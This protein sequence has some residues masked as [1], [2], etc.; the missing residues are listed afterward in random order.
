[1]A[2]AISTIIG[3]SA[4]AAKSKHARSKMR[5]HFGSAL[6]SPP[7]GD[8]ISGTDVPLGSFRCKSN[9]FGDS[10]P[11]TKTA[12]VFNLCRDTWLRS[13]RFVAARKLSRQCVGR[14]RATVR[15]I[16]VPRTGGQGAKDPRIPKRIQPLFCRIVPRFRLQFQQLRQVSDRR[17]EA[18]AAFR[19]AAHPLRWA[20]ESDDS[21]G[22]NSLIDKDIGIDP[23]DR[24]SPFKRNHIGMGSQF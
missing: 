23:C 17:F 8:S 11:Q 24:P 12:H 22:F 2:A 5:F 16:V 15:G 14:V 13:V 9:I 21:K 6:Q 20:C 18:L 10:V 19:H 7:Q 4:G 3:M 1:M